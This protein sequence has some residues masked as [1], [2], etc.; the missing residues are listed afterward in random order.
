MSAGFAS[1]EREV[2]GSAAGGTAL[3]P[4]T[5]TLT[6]TSARLKF[7]PGSG[8]LQGG[9]LS[10]P[11]ADILRVDL[12]AT[13]LVIPN[14]IVVVRRDGRKHELVVADRDGWAGRIRSLLPLR[15]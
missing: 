9:P 3:A 4:T 2:A 8:L 11:L 10:I 15:A 7:E 13:A 1:R 5:G 12:G 14:R 6:L